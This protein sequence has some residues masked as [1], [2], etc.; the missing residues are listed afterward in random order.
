MTGCDYMRY[1]I[2]ELG[3][4]KTQAGSAAEQTLTAVFICRDLF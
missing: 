4:L 3:F 2:L 1:Y